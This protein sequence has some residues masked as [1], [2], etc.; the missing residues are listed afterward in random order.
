M[1]S[2]DSLDVKDGP[3]RVGGVL[4]FCGVTDQTLLI[5]ESHVRGRD[6]VSLVID[7][8]FNLSVLHQT[9]ATVQVSTLLSAD[10]RVATYEYVVPK[11]IPTTIVS[12]H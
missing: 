11:S 2:R 8:D 6:T 12:K 1:I 10:A 5:R 3:R 4:V 7:E 9:D